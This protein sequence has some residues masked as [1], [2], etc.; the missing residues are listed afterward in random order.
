MTDKPASSRPP[1][2]SEEAV[3]HF[4]AQLPRGRVNARTTDELCAEMGI[5]RRKFRL[6][7]HVAVTEYRLLCCSDDEGVFIPASAEEARD[8]IAR[9]YSHAREINE[10]ARLLKDVVAETY[11]RKPPTRLTPPPAKKITPGKVIMP[12]HVTLV[13]EHQLEMPLWSPVGSN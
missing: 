12:F 7:K 4:Y 11:G 1:A 9:L 5:N 10:Q 6:L 3:R 2:P 13:S 8:A